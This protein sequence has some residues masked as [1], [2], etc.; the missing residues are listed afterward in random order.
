[1]NKKAHFQVDARLASLLGEN[2]RSSEHALKELVDNA[3][4]AD[5]SKIWI[6]LP[7]PMTSDPLI[8]KDDGSGMTEKEVTHEYLVVASSRTSR[9]GEQTP[10]K[11]RLVK[12]RKG[13]GK[14]AGLLAANVM[15]IQTFARSK[16]TKIII[17]KKSLLDAGKDL[18]VIDLPYETFPCSEDEH[19]TTITLTDLN[20]NLAFPDP[21]N[22]KQILILEY[23]RKTEFQIF[24]NGNLLDIDDIP[25]QT[26]CEKI[27]IP[28]IGEV[29]LRFTVAD[30]KK[31]LKQ[32]GI[33]IRVNGKIVGQPKYFGL[34]DD[35]E[36]PTKLIRRVYGEI[37]ADGLADDVT[38]DWGA[39]IENSM[40]L[41]K[42]QDWVYPKLKNGMRTVYSQDINLQKARLQQQINRQLEKL[43]EYKRDF[44]RQ[45]LEKVLFK[46]YGESEYRIKTIISVVL[47]AFEKDE[48]WIVLQT[49][50]E[51]KRRDVET[52]A[53]ALDTFGLLDMALVARQARSRLQFLDELEELVNNNKTLEKT[54]HKALESNLWVFGA[55]YSL[56]SSEKTLAS[57]IEKYTKKKFSGERAVKRPDLFLAKYHLRHHLLIEFKRPSHTLTRDDENQA[58]KYRDD[59]RSRFGHIKIIVIGGDVD[60]K[61]LGNSH[62]IDTQLM[63]YP[64]LIS[65]ARAELNWLIDN[66]KRA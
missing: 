41:R 28:E 7:D 48:Y 16:S 3:W 46:F 52:F 59:L 6:D 50:D 53:E 55:E 58:E 31:P 17:D 33:A 34:D 38:A 62:P 42:V 64:L 51:S 36:I 19:G 32:S 40:A 65:N 30:G 39:I 47:E 35:E 11:N 27:F 23:G 43:P 56:I 60:R 29:N 44:A 49:I 54:V 18:E 63:T 8:I 9:K 22:L 21:E 13:I 12:G 66:L 45:A 10:L 1:M 57:I 61:I 26:F 4:D 24:V 37:E 20:Q 14:F 15:E 5:A 2:Y 25:G